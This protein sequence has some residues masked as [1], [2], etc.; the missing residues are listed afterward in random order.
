MVFSDDLIMG[1]GPTVFPLLSVVRLRI[2]LGD[3]IIPKF[4]IQ[5]YIRSVKNEIVS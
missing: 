1:K 4:Q 3:A 2:E 5:E